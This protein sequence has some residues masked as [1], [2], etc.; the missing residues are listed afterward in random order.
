MEVNMKILIQIICVL[1]T[2]VYFLWTAGDENYTLQSEGPVW[3]DTF[4]IVDIKSPLDGAI[5]KA[6]FYR[7]RSAEAKPLIVS[8]H[9]WSHD[10]TQFDSINDLCVS[11][12]LNYIHP[13]FR[14]VNNHKDA[15]CSE[16]VLSDIDAAI[17]YALANGNVDIDRIYVIGTSGGGYAT[18]ATFMKSRHNI[19]KFAA[20][21]PLVD[22]A[23]WYRES[24]IRKLKYAD[25]IMTCTSSSGGELNLEVARRKSP[26][27]WPTPVNKLEDS[28]VKIYCG[29]Y[30]GMTGNGTIPITHSIN[31][32]NKLMDDV[33]G[34]AIDHKVS[35]EEKLHLLEHRSSLVQD[36]KIGDR[37]VF[38]EK[39]HGNVHLILFE[40]GHEILTKYA[41]NDLIKDN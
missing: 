23:K 32:Y 38:L 16:L 21:V 10:Y 34:H 37:E 7:S 39:S 19:K 9:T 40:G 15:C 27:Y 14:G 1:L 28:E 36:R 22:L 31:F 5:Q 18:L 17:D 3:S 29:V 12:D 33:G 6:Y 11:M 2:P 24:R 25:E 13:N 20:W 26:I 8:L 41:F 35:D 30:D 4:E